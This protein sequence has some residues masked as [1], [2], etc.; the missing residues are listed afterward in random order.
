MSATEPSSTQGLQEGTNNDTTDTYNPNT[1]FSTTESDPADA[2]LPPSTS[3]L[4]AIAQRSKATTPVQ[5]IATQDAYDQWADIYDSDGNMLQSID[6]LELETMLPE[7]LDDVVRSLSLTGTPRLNIIDLGCGTGRNTAKLLAYPW[8]TSSSSSPR[9]IEINITGLDFSRGMLDVAKQKLKT[10]VE[11]GN[12]NLRLQQADCFPTVSDKSASSIP[13]VEGLAPANAVISTL[14][15]EHIPL[16]DYFATLAAL[17][18][19][20]GYALVTNMHSEMGRL[21]QAGF[22]NAQGVKVRGT[23]FVFTPQVPAVAARG[24]GFEVVRLTERKMDAGVVEN[25]LVS[26]RGKKWIGINVWYGLVLVKV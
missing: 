11:H 14:V 12:V 8:P 5:H 18:G 19:K 2:D 3:R 1:S 9:T 22:V 24:A 6:D 23:S 16:Q 7:F 4:N 15:L 17:V 26:E 20:G 13:V 10:P 21:S 25:G